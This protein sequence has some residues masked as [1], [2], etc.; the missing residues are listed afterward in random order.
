[1]RSS[2]TR[3]W[4]PRPDSNRHGFL[5]TPLKRARLPIPPLG[6]S[7]IERSLACARDD[8]I[9]SLLRG[10]A[11]R[12]A[13]HHRRPR[14]RLQDR[15]R[16]RREN[17]GNEE[18]GRELVQKRRR[19]ARAER[20]LRAAATERAGEIRALPLLHED[21]EDQEQAD[22][23]VDDDERNDH[24]WFLR[25]PPPNEPGERIL[26]GFR[27]GVKPGAS[28]RKSL[29]TLRNRDLRRRRETR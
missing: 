23:D 11:R 10:R 2:S 3:L 5:H 4:C 9:A 14:M 7:K 19:A 17:E 26:P 18:P 29:E 25:Y 6:Q 1:M 8:A 12:G 20:C 13:A 28:C 16:E 24:E 27:R 21:D 22:D 15:E